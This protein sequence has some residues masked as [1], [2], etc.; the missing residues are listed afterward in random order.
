MFND[1]QWTE[2]L[3]NLEQLEAVNAG[4]DGLTATVG[5]LQESLQDI[6][7]V[8]GDVE[9]LKGATIIGTLK[10]IVAMIENLQK[11]LPAKE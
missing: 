6:E 9:E 10:T 1:D 11:N 2:I 3:E 5:T 8:L 4:L 7:F